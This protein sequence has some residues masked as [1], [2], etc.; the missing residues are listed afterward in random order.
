M[1]QRENRRASNPDVNLRA[2][3]T[4]AI[5]P[6]HPACYP[7]RAGRSVSRAVNISHCRYDH[8]QS[9]AVQ[10]ATQL[11]GYRESCWLS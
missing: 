1:C 7:H 2:S 5:R 8:V 11:T 3:I 4:G 10:R 9:Q 6:Q